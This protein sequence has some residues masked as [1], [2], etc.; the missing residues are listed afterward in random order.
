MNYPPGTLRQ[1][2]GLLGPHHYLVLQCHVA[3]L[4]HADTCR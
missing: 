2:S 3:V 1:L 4:R